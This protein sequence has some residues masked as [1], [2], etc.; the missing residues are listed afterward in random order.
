MFCM[1]SSYSVTVFPVLSDN[2]MLAHQRLQNTCS[3]LIPLWPVTNQ[4]RLGKA[5]R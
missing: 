2:I 1:I 3:D 5:M 4:M